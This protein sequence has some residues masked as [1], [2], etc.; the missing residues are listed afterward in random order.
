MNQICEDLVSKRQA[1]QYMTMG[2]PFM[3]RAFIKWAK[4]ADIPKSK[5]LEPFAGHN[6]LI[7]HLSDMGLCDKFSSFDIDPPNRKIK[8]RDTLARFPTG[9]DV[10][11]TN[12]PWLAK[13][14]ATVRKM[15]FPITQYDNLYK[16]ALDKCLSNCAWVAAL[17]PES[18]IRAN[19]FGERLTD[20]I[21]LK[22]KMFDDTDHPV[23]L[24]LFQPNPCNDVRVW[25]PNK[26]RLLSTLESLRPTSAPDGPKVRFN[27]PDG[28][29]G[30]IALDNTHSASIRFCNVDELA[31]YRVKRTGR[32]ITK[33]HVDGDIRIDAWNRYI[34]Y[35]RSKTYDVLMTC[36]KGIRKDGMYRRRL[37]W[38]LAR[39]IIHNG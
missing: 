20:F 10:C 3:H 19:V 7:Q 8:R 29:V 31:D 15:T 38:E 24:A 27:D 26:F 35:F 11:I 5:I 6:Y 2:N 28:N 34:D 4:H 32:H 25:V 14:S 13:N 36:Y 33:I 23:G 39:G 17:V 22:S 9:Y 1:G 21:S 37:D 12:P 18:F 16:L 30:L